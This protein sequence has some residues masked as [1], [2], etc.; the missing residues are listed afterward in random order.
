MKK[1][2]HC[3][4]AWRSNFHFPKQKLR[5]LPFSS[6]HEFLPLVKFCSEGGCASE[7]LNELIPTPSLFSGPLVVA[8]GMVRGRPPEF[9]VR[10]SRVLR[11][12]IVGEQIV[13]FQGR[14]RQWPRR[15]WLFGLCPLQALDDL[16]LLMKQR[17]LLPP[18]V[19][20]VVTEEVT[21]GEHGVQVLLR[22]AHPGSFHAAL[23]HDFVSALDAARTNRVPLA[24]EVGVIQHRQAGLEVEER[25]I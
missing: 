22:P 17:N 7:L 1:N 6:I 24:A 21:Q 11:S 15:G 23:D 18:F 4:S 10:W 12:V 9:L 14:E 8:P 20:A 16:L 2:R 19:P 13:C 5:N 3:C 25:A